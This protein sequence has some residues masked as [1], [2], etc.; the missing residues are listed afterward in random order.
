MESLSRRS[1]Q[2]A[3]VDQ[4]PRNTTE[5]QK[6]KIGMLV[7]LTPAP[8]RTSDPNPTRTCPVRA[9]HHSC[10]QGNI[11]D[12]RLH[13]HYIIHSSCISKRCICNRCIST[14]RVASRRGSHLILYERRPTEVRRPAHEGLE[15]ASRE[16]ELGEKKCR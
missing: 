10:H 6:R 7:Q 3:Q 15:A 12:P 14:L 16:T 2:V 9:P 5:R 4:T 8:S 11:T 13:F 1:C